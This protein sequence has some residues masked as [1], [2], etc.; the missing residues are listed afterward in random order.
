[1]DEQSPA[2]APPSNGTVPARSGRKSETVQQTARQEMHGRG[3]GAIG[4]RGGVTRGSMAGC[5]VL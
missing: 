1:M 2:P 3:G 5:G 4:G